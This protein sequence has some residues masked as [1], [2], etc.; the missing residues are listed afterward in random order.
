MEWQGL[1]YRDSD[2]ENDVLR[3]FP[4]AS[5]MIRPSPLTEATILV[6]WK[7]DILCYA[8]ADEL[9]HRDGTYRPYWYPYHRL[10]E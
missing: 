8:I 9:R 7:E 5:V 4:Q 6:Y 3:Y 1:H 10:G 2:N